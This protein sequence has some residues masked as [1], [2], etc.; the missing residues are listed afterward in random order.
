MNRVDLNDWRTHRLPLPRYDDIMDKDK[1]KDGT[2]DLRSVD[3][4]CL[5]VLK[6]PL[7]RLRISGLALVG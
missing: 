5:S 6:E 7:M 4:T 1:N 3:N 2:F